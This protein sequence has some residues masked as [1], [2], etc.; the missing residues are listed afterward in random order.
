MGGVDPFWETATFYL[1][2]RR[3]CEFLPRAPSVVAAASAI[4]GVFL[5]GTVI[6]GTPRVVVVTIDRLSRKEQGP[7]L[8][9]PRSTRSPNPLFFVRQ[10][11]G[12]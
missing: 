12:P 8:S 3:C 6:S 7:W 5:V 2:T 10:V 11:K 9:P 4:P 1:D